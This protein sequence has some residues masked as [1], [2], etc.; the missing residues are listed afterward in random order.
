[1]YV[2]NNALPTNKWIY[3]E[4]KIWWRHDMETLSVLLA[5]CEGTPPAAVGFPSQMASN[6]EFWFFFR[7]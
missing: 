6:A 1:M 7:C 4:I 3:S 5:L 2:Y